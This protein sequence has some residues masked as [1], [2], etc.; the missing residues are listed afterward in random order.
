MK[1]LKR[2]LALLMSAA[3]FGGL[4]PGATITSSAAVTLEDTIL[5]GMANFATE[6]DV[7]PF[8]SASDKAAGYPALITAFRNALYDH[9]ELYWYDWFK[10]GKD[11]AGKNAFIGTSSTDKSK[12]YLMN[13]KYTFSKA[14]LPAAQAKFDAAVKTALAGIGSDWTEVEKVLYIHDYIIQNAAYFQ[15]MTD[16]ET[17]YD[18]LVNGLAMCQSYALTTKLLLDKVGIPSLVI[19]TPNASHSWNYVKIGSNWFHLDVDVD[20]TVI[21]T[22]GDKPVWHDQYGR[23]LHNWVLTSD[24]KARTNATKHNGWVLRTFTYAGTKY[25]PVAASKTTYDKYPWVNSTSA[26]VKLGDYWYYTDMQEETY[27]KGYTG[28]KYQV[29]LK[30]FS[31]DTKKTATVRKLTAVWYKNA[32]KTTLYTDKVFVSLGVYNGYLYY[33]LQDKIV[34]YKPAVQS[35]DGK[36]KSSTSTVSKVVPSSAQYVYGFTINQNTGKMTYIIKSSTTSA[37]KKWSKTL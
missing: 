8:V 25:T 36:A 34:R 33:N 23:V 14:T 12:V 22:G 24:T 30:R 16:Y 21:S 3:I 10:S 31:F 11:A 7:T 28:T 6:I 4:L 35:A 13:L 26:M 15:A 5:A 9:P 29:Y 2:L 20:D 37:S 32:A 19:Y 18:P 17:S 27:A 1:K